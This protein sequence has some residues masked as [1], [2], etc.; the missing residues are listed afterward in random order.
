MTV[1]FAPQAPGARMGAVQLTDNL[2]NVLVTTMLHGQ[3]QGPAITFGPGTQTTPATGLTNSQGVAVDAAGD[4]FI[5]NSGSNQ[6]VEIPT[7][8]GSQLTLGSGLS[9][10]MGLAVDGAGNVFIADQGNNRVVEVPA[11][12]GPQTTVG[13]GLS[14]P[15]GVNA[16]ES[17]NIFIA[18]TGNNRVVE[19]PA[20]GGSQITVGTGL[21]LPSGIAV[22]ASGNVFIADAGDNQIVEVPGNSGPQTTMGT[23][24]NHPD[25]VAVDAAG[26]L[27]IAD[28]GNARVVEI[29]AGGGPQTT[30][31]AGLI[32]PDAIAVDG[33]GDVFI[34]DAGNNNVVEVQL[35]QVPSLSFASTPPGGT[36]SDSPQSVI[37]QNIGN[38]SL[39]AVAP[40]LVVTGPN[41]LQVT[42]SGTPA[43]CSSTFSLTPGATCNLSISFEPQSIGAFT[44]TAVFTDNALNTSP[45]ASQSLALQGTGAQQAQTI[46]FGAL[47]NQPIGTAPFTVSAT[48]SSGLTVSFASTTT[49][50]CTVSGTTVTLVSTGT[51]T[52]RAT[53]AGNTNYAAA[54]PVNQSFQVTLLTQTI[55]FGALSNQAVG[56]TPF[57]VSATASSGLTVS[58]ASTTPSVCTVSSA[59]VTLVATGT[60]TIEAT[61]AGNTDYAAATP[62]DQSFQVGAAGSSLAGH[63]MSQR[64]RPG[65]S[66]RREWRRHSR[67]A[68][69]RRFDGARSGGDQRHRRAR[70]VQTEGVVEAKVT[71]SP[72]DAVALTV[73]GVAPTA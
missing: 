11:G 19:V 4:L 69:L 31:G 58:F 63:V 56:A 1:S 3:G 49:S 2:G 54:T 6:V 34:A 36:S 51:C 64:P 37:V 48:A 22:D 39:A 53:Q 13:T 25:A 26:D 61:Q 18:D 35:S 16:D 68:R 73:N 14:G 8:G 38:Q 47:S 72:E 15:V 10:P 71:V 7:G 43:D 59:M 42:G 32:T 52:I 5:A 66:G 57:T 46:T 41:F 67:I 28:T 20:G 65:S 44:S 12:G 17:G 24:L 60:C 70:H 45:S 9:S 29:P 27:F 33:A 40:G 23:G 50:V 21:N 30:V 55:T 62:V